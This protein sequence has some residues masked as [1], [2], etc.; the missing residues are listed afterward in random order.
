MMTRLLCGILTLLGLAVPTG[1]A[2]AD[3]KYVVLREVKDGVLVYTNLTEEVFQATKRAGQERYEN[4]QREWLKTRQGPRPVEPRYSTIPGTYKSKELADAAGRAHA[5]RTGYF[6]CWRCDGTGEHERE[7]ANRKHAC[8]VCKGAKRIRG[9]GYQIVKITLDRK[10]TYG[11]SRRDVAGLIPREAGAGGAGG[12]GI[13]SGLGDKTYSFG[14]VRDFPPGA[15]DQARQVHQ[16]MLKAAAGQAGFLQPSEL[17][18]AVDSYLAVKW[19]DK[20]YER[21]R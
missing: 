7:T 2:G 13:F 9:N 17:N 21:V 18:A 6:T 11:L 1:H 20:F 15:Y 14:N 5:D 12:S 4:E 10:W 16:E 19:P 8:W 3:E